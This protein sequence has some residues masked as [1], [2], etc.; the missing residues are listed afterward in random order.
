ML[1]SLLCERKL[2]F[3]SSR[4]ELL[5][6]VCEGFVGLLYPFQWQ[7]LYVP[8]MPTSIALECVQV[9]VMF[10]LRFSVSSSLLGLAQDLHLV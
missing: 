10:L 4:L 9:G 2:M 3:Y 1:A 5:T 7:C 8:V 6:P